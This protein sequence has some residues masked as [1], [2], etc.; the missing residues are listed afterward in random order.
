MSESMDFS[1]FLPE[2]NVIPAEIAEV[3]AEIFKA[4]C[5]GDAEEIYNLLTALTGTAE[6]EDQACEYLAMLMAGFQVAASS[7]YVSHVMVHES[8]IEDKIGG[9]ISEK[10]ASIPEGATV[11]D[12]L[13]ALGL[14]TELAPEVEY[15][16][17]GNEAA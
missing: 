9:S 8:A 12:I 16:A 5:K 15:P 17:E 11:D 1:E 13:A 7:V 10:L 14:S 4:A 2:G 3:G 6:G